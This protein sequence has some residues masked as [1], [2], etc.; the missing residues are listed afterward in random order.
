MLIVGFRVP[1][2]SCYF[3]TLGLKTD[4]VFCLRVVY[5]TRNLKNHVCARLLKHVLSIRVIIIII[6][7]DK[8]H[9]KNTACN[10]SLLVHFTNTSQRPFDIIIY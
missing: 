7:F 6:L 3:E 1:M 9:T 8:E 5:K 2:P 4:F 10:S